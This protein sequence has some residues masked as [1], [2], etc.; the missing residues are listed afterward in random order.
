MSLKC[1]TKE[2]LQIIIISIRRGSGRHHSSKSN[3]L[4]LYTVIFHQDVTPI[5]L[6]IILI[7]FISVVCYF[8]DNTLLFLV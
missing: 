2:L 1:S 8:K 4:N 6:L 7:I 5:L 3:F